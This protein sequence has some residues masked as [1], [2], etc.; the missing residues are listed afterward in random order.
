[1]DIWNTYAFPKSQLSNNYF[2][3]SHL[4][5]E[6]FNNDKISPS[7]SQTLGNSKIATMWSMKAK[8]LWPISGT[9]F[10]VITT[11]PAYAPQPSPSANLCYG[12]LTVDTPI[13]CCKPGNYKNSSSGFKSK[14]LHLIALWPWIRHL[15]SLSLF[16]CLL[17]EISFIHSTSID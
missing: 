8:N 4:S 6:E 13:S 16:L 15:N 1:M 9:T 17:N 7:L 12:W 14:L 3:L 10:P 5:S 2:N 11:C